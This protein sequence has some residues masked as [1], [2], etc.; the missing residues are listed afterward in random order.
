MNLD[1]DYRKTEKSSVAKHANNN[2]HK[3]SIQQGQNIE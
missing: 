1:V 3:N 2:G